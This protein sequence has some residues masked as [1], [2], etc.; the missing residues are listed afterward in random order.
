MNDI[1]EKLDEQERTEQALAIVRNPKPDHDSYTYLSQAIRKYCQNESEKIQNNVARLVA[2]IIDTAFLDGIIAEREALIQ[3][4]ITIYDS[5]MNSNCKLKNENRKLRDQNQS[6]L[7]TRDE[8]EKAIIACDGKRIRVAE[9]DPAYYGAVKC[10]EFV[11]ERTRNINMASKAF[12]C[13]LLGGKYPECVPDGPE[14]FLDAKEAIREAYK[15]DKE[16]RI[17]I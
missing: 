12:D 5:W 8:I 11:Y 10:Y 14:N 3:N 1:D 13:Y 4:E 16:G 6:L 2:K 7:V 15:E 9:T 17:R